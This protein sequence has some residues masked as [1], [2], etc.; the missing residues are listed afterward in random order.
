MSPAQGNDTVA[1][2]MEKLIQQAMVVRFALPF[3]LTHLVHECRTV[4]PPV[5]QEDGH[6][7]VQDALCCAEGAVRIGGASDN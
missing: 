5:V 2:T 4:H 1:P 7:L 6:T 3:F